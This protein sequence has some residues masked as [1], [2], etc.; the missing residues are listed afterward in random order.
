MRGTRPHARTDAVHSP[1]EQWKQFGRE[2][3]DIKFGFPL[4]AAAEPEPMKNR[5]RFDARAPMLRVPPLSLFARSRNNRRK[6][7]TIQARVRAQRPS[8]MQLIN[9]GDACINIRHGCCRLISMTY[10]PVARQYRV[11]N[12]QCR[13]TYCEKETPLI[14]L[15]TET[16]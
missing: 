8:G 6:L 4:R 2:T 14:Y 5:Y 16:D 15:F 11:R 9:V 1:R 7:E 3:E 13:E 12:Q 10:A